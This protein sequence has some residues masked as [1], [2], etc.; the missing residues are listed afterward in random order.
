MSLGLSGDVFAPRLAAGVL[1]I[2]VFRRVTSKSSQ[3][4]LKCLEAERRRS[5]DL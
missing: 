5:D 4:H 3:S 2:A 1:G